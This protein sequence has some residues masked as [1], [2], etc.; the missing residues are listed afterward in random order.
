MWKCLG[1]HV[2]ILMCEFFCVYVC[3]CADPSVYARVC[4]NFL[5]LCGCA[6]VCVSTLRELVIPIS[7]FLLEAALW[8]KVLGVGGGEKPKPFLFSP[9]LQGTPSL[10]RLSPGDGLVVASWQSGSPA[11]APSGRQG[12]VPSWGG[13]PVLDSGPGGG[14]LWAGEW[15]CAL[16]GQGSPSEHPP[17]SHPNSDLRLIL[18]TGQGEIAK[19]LRCKTSLSLSVWLPPPSPSPP[20]ASFHLCGPCRLGAHCEPICGLFFLCLSGLLVRVG[21]GGGRRGGGCG[22][23]N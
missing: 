9:P 6:R 8:E 10:G 18:S 20:R 14:S 4:V 5:H 7:T 12:K 3:L 1:V 17:N 19:P 23:G 22:K 21:G 16:S 2:C 11:R 15:D 13:G